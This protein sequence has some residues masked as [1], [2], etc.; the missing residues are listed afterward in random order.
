MDEC[1]NPRSVNHNVIRPYEVL[2]T[3]PGDFVARFKFTVLVMPTGINMVTGLPFDL[4]KFESEHEV[5]DQNLKVWFHEPIQLRTYNY[6]N[7][8]SVCCC[9]SWFW[10]QYP[11]RR[12]RARPRRRMARRVMPR[13]N[14]FLTSR[15][16]KSKNSIRNVLCHEGLIIYT[17]FKIIKS[18]KFG[19]NMKYC[20]NGSCKIME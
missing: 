18:F 16:Y 14:K 13:R 9:R 5:L 10:H 17:D 19:K 11:A 4:E 3:K 8:C 1:H 15:H 2:Y 7:W 6:S 20:K 12:R